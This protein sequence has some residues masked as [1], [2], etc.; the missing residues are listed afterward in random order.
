MKKNRKAIF[1]S[2]LV[3]PGL[4]QL[5]FQRYKLAGG[6]FLVMAISFYGMVSIAIEQATDILNKI[7][8]QGGALDVEAIINATTQATNS[9]DNS[10]FNLYLAVIAICWIM[11]I[12]DVLLVGKKASEI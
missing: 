8:I 1:L 5:V 4:G 6:I 2:A 7:N 12:V 10:M 3:L 11:S 9:T